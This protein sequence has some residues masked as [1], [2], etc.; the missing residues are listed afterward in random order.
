MLIAVAK[1]LEL[2]VVGRSKR[3]L[4]LGAQLRVRGLQP[5]CIGLPERPLDRC[6]RLAGLPEV[7][8]S[9]RE[10]EVP[11][12]LLEDAAKRVQTRA[13]RRQIRQRLPRPTQ[14]AKQDR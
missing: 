13:R 11:F 6:E 9:S 5:H 12:E 2:E 7:A 14:A 4:K 10:L 3:R 8:Q 1:Q